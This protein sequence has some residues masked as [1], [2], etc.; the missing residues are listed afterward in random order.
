VAWTNNSATASEFRIERKT[1]SGGAYAEI[2][3]DTASPYSDSTVAENTE[4]YYKVRAYRAS[5]GIYSGYCT[6]G[7]V[8]TGPTAPSNLQ[9][10][11]TVSATGASKVRVFW[12]SNSILENGF[13]LQRSTDNS[14]WSDLATTAMG[15]Q[16]YEDTGLTINT[17]YYYKVACIGFTAGSYSDYTTSI[18]VT[19][20]VG[21]VGD[22]FLAFQ[23]KVRHF[24]T[25]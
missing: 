6:E 8:T 7:N 16:S 5:D 25:S 10:G 12:D 1:G 18:A 15:I 24:P 9:G 4:Y 20:T 14:T 2:G 21:K 23:K 13:K 17:T 11:C 22:L 19:T 3:T